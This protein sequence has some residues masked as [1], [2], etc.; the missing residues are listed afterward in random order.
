LLLKPLWRRAPAPPPDAIAGAV[1]A[2]AGSI[3]AGMPPPAAVAAWAELAPGEIAGRVSRR[4]ALGE[5]PA[6]AFLASEPE[7]GSAA[8]PL[9]RCFALY[10][11]TGGSLPALLERVA[12]A[13]ERDGEVARDAGAAT[14]GAR[15]SGRLVAGLPLAFVPLTPGG[16]VLRFGPAGAAVVVLGIALAAAGLWWIG[17]LVPAP[18]GADDG[19]ATL[20]DDLAVALAGGIGLGPALEAA[21][22]HPPTGLESALARAGRRASLGESWTKALRREGGALASLA[23]V[24][25]RSLAWG[26]PAAEPLREWARARRDEVRTEMQRSL[27]RA[28]V[29]MVVPLTVCVLPSFAL[30]AFGPLVLGAFGAR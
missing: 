14:S 1:R 11:A 7:L 17:R 29:L 28:P 2:L 5:T 19:A 22:E 15:L 10:T 20:A 16:S 3:R 30:L 12:E 23:A 6:A 24:V 21:A 13:V 9:A 18:P 4:V 25:A 26:V 8:G 27:R